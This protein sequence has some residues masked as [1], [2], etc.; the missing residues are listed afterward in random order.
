MFILNKN[1]FYEIL[2]FMVFLKA[3]NTDSRRDDLGT[4]GVGI[5]ANITYR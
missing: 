5:C 4:V 1:V 3:N 2:S